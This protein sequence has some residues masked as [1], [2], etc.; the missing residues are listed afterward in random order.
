MAIILAVTP[1]KVGT[2]LF[3]LTTGSY[4]TALGW[5]S[6]ASDRE[7]KFNAAV[8]A[9]TLVFNVADNNTATGAGAFLTNTTGKENTANGAFALFSNTGGDFNTAIGNEAL[10]NNTTGNTNTAVGDA[11]LSINTTG[12]NNTAIGSDALQ[13]NLTGNGNVALGAGAGILITQGNNNID[14]GNLVGVTGDSATIRIDNVQTRTFIAGISGIPVTGTAVVVDGSGQLGVAPSSKR[15]KEG[16]RP[17][18]NDSE[19]ILALKPVTFHYKKEIDP[20]NTAQFGLVAEEVENVNPD[21]V[22]RDEEGKPY[23]VRYDQV[24][25]MLLNEFLKEHLTV[26][27]Q[28][29]TIAQQQKEM[30]ALKAELKEKALQ[31]QKIG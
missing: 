27:D 26:K 6:L 5:D 10:Q 19:T 24:N 23:S 13:G 4:N 29:T 12:V 2:P 9:G 1:Q 20:K 7:G 3:S 11:A 22:V 16:I 21:L 18:D 15:F 14:I 31:I 25:A 8:G 17:M 30:K 28:G